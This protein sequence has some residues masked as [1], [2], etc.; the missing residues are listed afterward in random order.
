MNYAHSVFAKNATLTSGGFPAFMRTFGKDS[1]LIPGLEE[2][3]I[4]VTDEWVEKRVNETNA[5]R[6]PVIQ[7]ER[8]AKIKHSMQGNA[9][10]VESFHA[11]DEGGIFEI[12]VHKK[13][14][15][16]EVLPK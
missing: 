14:K 9:D 8:E 4:R 13:N 16:G 3:H 10:K 12:F 2:Q 1:Q 7:A 5:S 6:E 11:V 15:G